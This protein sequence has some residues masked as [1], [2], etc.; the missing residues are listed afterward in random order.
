MK[1]TPLFDPK[2]HEA[3]KNPRAVR[4]LYDHDE[5]LVLAINVAL[6]TR[7]PLLLRGDPGSGKSTVAADIAF[8]LGRTYHEQVITS[9]IQAQDL[10]FRFDAVRRLG[11]IQASATG[12]SARVA[13]SDAAYVEPG[14]L[15]WAFDPTSASAHGRR[16]STS[17]R[18]AAPK[19]RKGAVVLLDEIDKADPDVPNDLL[20][21]LDSHWF[22]VPELDHKRIEAPKDLA[23]LLVITTNG[24]RELPAAFLRRC[25]VYDL[26]TP[27]GKDLTA[28]V[29][30]HFPVKEVSDTIVQAAQ[31]KLVALTS[32]AAKARLRVPS[33]ASSSTP[34]AP[35]AT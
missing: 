3:R 31:A 15:W 35:V 29:R 11:A 34:S 1:Y 18:A 7:R 22:D 23:L 33:T 27:E 6:A 10:L 21:V 12:K 25:V 4:Y 19:K 14:V 26:K 32:D 16:G 28:I 17:K 5:H 9:R 20:V 8:C 2:A 24:E 30:Q 13:D